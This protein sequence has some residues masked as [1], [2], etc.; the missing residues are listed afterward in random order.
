MSSSEDKDK[1]EEVPTKK[2]AGAYEDLEDMTY[3]CIGG[4]AN[5]TGLHWE[6]DF[7]GTSIL[8]LFLFKVN[9]GEPTAKMCGK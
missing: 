8:T 2:F 1:D 6:M 3:G 5:S 4:V 9:F 7:G